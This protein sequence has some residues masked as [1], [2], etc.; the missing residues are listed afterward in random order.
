MRQIGRTSRIATY[1][2]DQLL[3]VGE[4]I[5]TDHTTFEYSGSNNDSSLKLLKDKVKL[6]VEAQSYGSKTCKGTI[7]EVKG[8]NEKVIHFKIKSNVDD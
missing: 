6:L 7:K 4:C 5:V 8:S 2:A 3:S 1:T